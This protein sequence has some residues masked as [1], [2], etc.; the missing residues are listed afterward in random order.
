VTKVVQGQASFDLVVRYDPAVRG[1]L[2]A[3]RATLITTPGG[4]R[5]PLAALAEIRN[6]RGPY[7]I[8]RENVQRKI[9]VM[10]NVAGRDLKSVV[11]EMQAKLARDIKLPAG[12]HI[13]FGGQFE[14]AAEASRTLL[15]LGDGGR[16]RHLP[17]A[18]MSPSTARATPSW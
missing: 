14:S 8:N 16:G 2:D 12:Y 13:E 5:L 7:F 15:L 4:A 17:A 6:D 10:A 3:I 11:E 9:V 18:V 1:N